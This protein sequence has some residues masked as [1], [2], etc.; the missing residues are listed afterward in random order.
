M[1]EGLGEMFTL[2]ELGINAGLART[3]VTTNLI[4]SPNSVMRRVS[5]RVTNYKD[6]AVAMRC[7]ASGFLEGDRSL[8]R[9]RG[10]AQ[11]PQLI[12]AL[13]GNP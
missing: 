10:Y 8:R 13:L 2:K 3:M 7:T 5:G 9:I 11:T 1:I 4:E 12:A 6:A